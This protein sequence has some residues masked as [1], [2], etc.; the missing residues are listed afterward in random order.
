MLDNSLDLLLDGLVTDARQRLMLRPPRWSREEETFLRENLGKLSYAEIGAALG[1]SENAVKIRQVRR[2]M[3]APSKLEGSLTGNIAARALGADVKTVVK[4]GERGILPMERVPGERGILRISK[5]RLYMWAI[6][7]DHWI[8]F[9][10]RRMQ[11]RHL[12][13]L[14]RLAQSRWEDE[15]W[16]IGQAER[17]LGVKMGL[18]NSKLHRQKLG[19][20]LVRWG[21]FWI[22]KSD[23]LQIVIFPSDYNHE[24]VN[25]YSPRADAFLLR[26]AKEGIPYAVIGA[27]MGGWSRH[28][29]FHRLKMLGWSAAPGS[30]KGPRRKWKMP[31]GEMSGRQNLLR[32]KARA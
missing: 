7:P 17:Y 8:Y 20:R 32:K 25:H 1:R 13:G 2:R 10:V 19:Q 16:T 9:K 11:D 26:A 12:Q 5:L 31:V 28:E 6:N 15:W 3:P 18:L 29:V 22:R 14:V 23:A 21:N 27:M 30:V 4:L 24:G